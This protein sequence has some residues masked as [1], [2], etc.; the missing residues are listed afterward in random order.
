MQTQQS[1]HHW[2]KQTMTISSVDNNTIL[3]KNDDPSDRRN[4]QDDFDEF[5]YKS[6]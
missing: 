6:K 4:G 3:D 5:K 1:I 2:Y